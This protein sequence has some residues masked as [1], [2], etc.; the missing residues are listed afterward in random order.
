MNQQG[1]SGASRQRRKSQAKIQRAGDVINSQIV[2]GDNNV[3]IWGDGNVVVQKISRSQK[4]VVTP[5]PPPVSVGR[6]GH[7]IYLLDREAEKQT[8]DEALHSGIPLEFYC[9]PGFGKS[10]LLRYFSSQLQLSTGMVLIEMRNRMPLEDL[11]QELF[12]AFYQCD[13]IYKPSQV[14]YKR[15]FETI[16]ALI[17][18]DDVNLTR[19]EIQ[20]LRF[21][22]PRCVFLIAAA[23]QR[24][25]G[26]GNAIHLRGL[27][28]K[29]SLALVQRQVGR[30]LTAKELPLVKSICSTLQGNPLRIIEAVSTVRNGRKSF[31]AI[32]QSVQT[33]TPE[34]SLHGLSLNALPNSEKSM[35][36]LLAVLGNAPLPAEHLAEILQTKEIAPLIKNLL[37][38]GLIKAHSPRY[39]LTGSLDAYLNRSWNLSQWREIVLRH[40]V[41]WSA[42][43]A[44][45][46]QILEATDA[47]FRVMESAAGANRWQEVLQIGQAIEPAYILGKRWGSWAQL[48]ALLL[49][50]SQALGEVAI[51]A[52]VLHQ[53]GSRALCMGQFQDAREYL[54]RALE[55]RREIG[56]QSGI[57]ATL[58]N[59]GQLPGAVPPRTPPRSN[60]GTSSSRGW[61]IGG[62]LGLAAVGIAFLAFRNRPAPFIPVPGPTDPPALVATEPPALTPTPPDPTLDTSAD[63]SL[64]TSSDASNASLTP[65]RT[66]RPSPT[67]TPTRSITPTRVP[68]TRTP[69]GTE[70]RVPNDI[71]PAPT[72]Y[73]PLQDETV[74]CTGDP[75][76]LSWSEPYDASGIDSYLV[77]LQYYDTA[78]IS[79]IEEQSVYTTAFDITNEV[80]AYCGYDLEWWVR[81]VDSEGAR[82]NA[83]QPVSFRVAFPAAANDPPPAPGI[84]SPAPDQ[85]FA[86]GFPTV[87][88]WSQ[89]YDPSGI[90]HYLVELYY[91]NTDATPDTWVKL[92]PLTVYWLVSGDPETDVV[93]DVKCG[94]QHSWR[95]RAI[96]RENATGEWSEW[97]NFYVEKSGGVIK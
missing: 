75:V 64:D 23:E 52:W 27:P 30:K 60:G 43:G 71:P 41:D 2:S 42:R 28:L 25:G 68:P 53:I 95:V 6:P 16:Q 76:A 15:Y 51:E 55:I 91:F 79:L 90:D 87:L 69:T 80:N 78:W 39:S 44:Q 82:G 49:R 12:E 67:P 21:A 19:E 93:S 33:T 26:E 36:A 32:A 11:F 5:F 22:L 7:P 35:L 88:K 34:E 37:Q 4:L 92:R 96:D 83:S 13:S 66:G 58:Q 54:T 74:Y 47:L 59:L 61:I 81:A 10:T 29:E 45:R 1:L 84:I 20:S 38:S 70:T 94:Y 77:T 18:L 24:L 56:D 8:A 89:P 31:E 50:A 57:Q 48:L 3:V 86:C 46:E 65:T 73:Y 40:F 72:I 63:G 97:T 85:T 9:P 14:Q 17:L 62:I